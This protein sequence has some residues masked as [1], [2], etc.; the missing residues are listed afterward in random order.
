[1]QLTDDE[2]CCDLPVKL[3]TNDSRGDKGAQFP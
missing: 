2:Q 1:M 3:C